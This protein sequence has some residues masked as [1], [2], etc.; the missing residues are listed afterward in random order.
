MSRKQ[1]E[2]NNK[3]DFVIY[4][5][6]GSDEKWLAKKNV[7]SKNS[8]GQDS[9]ANRYRDWENL[10]YLFRGIE[11]FAP[12]VNRVYFITDEQIPEWLE[13]NNSKLI[14]IDHKDYIPKQ[15]LPT[16][17]SH[18]IE[19]NFHRIKDL[20]EQ[21]VVFNDDFFITDHVKPTDFFVDG[22][23][24]DIFME[25]PIMCGGNTEV[26]PNILANQFN[27]LG[28]YFTRK[29]YKQQL[30]W[31]ILSLKYGMYFFYNL[32]MFFLPFPRFFGLL[33]PHFARPYLKSSFEEVWQLEGKALD[34]VCKHKFRSKE[35]MNVYVFRIWNILKG[36][37]VPANIFKMG[38]AFMI[39]EEDPAVYKAIAEQKYKLICINDECKDQDFERI[40]EQIIDS[41][42]KILPEK[43]SFEKEERLL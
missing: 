28:K 7:Y 19:L 2:I 43:C 35:D 6:D 9:N 14:L 3:I 30:K 10:K 5:V 25:Y 20:S 15:Y 26:F 42:E 8:L 38:K 18:P 41:F 11:K 33:T 40:K 17:S 21:F 1:R 23:P 37:F 13:T 32:I 36:N 4:W 27:M 24:K 34:A 16:F 31:K 29:K 12:W 39:H 22:K